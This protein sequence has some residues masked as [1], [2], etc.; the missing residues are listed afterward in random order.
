MPGLLEIRIPDA[1]SRA[2]QSPSRSLFVWLERELGISEEEHDGQGIR[3]PY[4]VQAVVR[5]KDVLARMTLSTP[6]MLAMVTKAFADRFVFNGD[7]AVAEVVSSDFVSVQS[8]IDKAPPRTRVRLTTDS[9]II[10]CN[11]GKDDPILTKQRI[12]DQALERWRTHEEIEPPE[13]SSADNL[14]VISMNGRSEPYRAHVLRRGWV[15][16]MDLRIHGPVDRIIAGNVLLGYGAMWGIGRATTV[17]AGRYY[18][19]EPSRRNV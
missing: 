2:G 17:G 14:E 5:G 13:F 18:L 9:P 19:S 4:S 8:M 11:G 12:I 10:F 15:G 3:K 1:R 7:W 6:D 16:V